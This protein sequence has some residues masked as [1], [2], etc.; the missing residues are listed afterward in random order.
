VAENETLNRL[1]AAELKAEEIIASADRQRTESIEQ[2]KR[3]AQAAQT[4]HA[5]DISEIVASLMAQAEQRAAQTIAELRR[6]YAERA[7][8]MKA[9]AELTKTQALD[10]AF[11]LLIGGQKAP[12]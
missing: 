11:N 1:L 8:A 12:P 5:H 6:R 10:A 2:G 7:D 9:A 4:K 3:D